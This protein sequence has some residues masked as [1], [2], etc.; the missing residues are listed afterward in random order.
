[1]PLML[2]HRIPR[3]HVMRHRVAQALAPHLRLVL[4]TDDRKTRATV[5]ACV[6]VIRRQFSGRH[7]STTSPCRNLA[8]QILIL[9]V[10]LAL[11]GTKFSARAP[12][13]TDD[14]ELKYSATLIARSS[15]CWKGLLPWLLGTSCAGEEY[16]NACNEGALARARRRET[17]GRQE[18]QSEAEELEKNRRLVEHLP[19]LPP[20]GNLLLGRWRN[21]EAPP[22]ATCPK[23]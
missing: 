18:N 20:E 12:S 11:A 19:R 5:A 14:R 21:V 8:R 3:T 9:L 1:M 17:G 13:G 7:L 4:P 15:T 10:A 23:A 16:A 6:C 2:V 22:P